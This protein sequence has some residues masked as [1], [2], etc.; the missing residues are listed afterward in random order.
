MT[1][2][3]LALQCVAGVAMVIFAIYLDSIPG[4]PS[5]GPWVLLI[6]GLVYMV[7]AGLSFIATGI[8]AGPRAKNRTVDESREE[9]DGRGIK[10]QANRTMAGTSRSPNLSRGAVD[11]K[12]Q[13]NPRLGPLLLVVLITMTAGAGGL[14]GAW[15]RRIRRGRLSC[16]WDSPGVKESTD[17][18]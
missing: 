7:V 9:E 5:F 17:A 10:T 16:A 6:I 11:P 13:R 3:T 18:G 12:Q 8:P 14:H 2:R 1:R 15:T 4:M